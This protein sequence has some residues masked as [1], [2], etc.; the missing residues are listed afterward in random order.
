MNEVTWT[1]VR[2]RVIGLAHP[3]RPTT[4]EF[5]GRPFAAE[6]LQSELDALDAQEPERDACTDDDAFRRAHAARDAR[7]E[8]L[9]DAQE[10]GVVFLAEQG[11]AYTS[12]LVM[13]G[14]HR[15][16]VREDLGPADRGIEPTGLDFA[17]W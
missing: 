16:T 6:A 5:A 2:D 4:A 14:P 9:Y 1:G 12:L 13:T 3:G 7:H 17:R 8:E 11:C 15:G 10:A